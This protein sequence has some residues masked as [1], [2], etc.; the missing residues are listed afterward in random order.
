[1]FSSVSHLEKMLFT[2]EFSVLLKSGV[3]LREALVSLEGKARRGS[4]R[5]VLQD[6]ESHIENGQPLSQALSRFPKVFDPLYVNLVRIGEASGTLPENLEFLSHELDQAYRLRKKIQGILLYPSIVFTLA[7]GLGAAI[8]VF[9]LPRLIRLFNSFDVALP[10]STRIL[11]GVASFMEA[12]GVLF[13][14]VLFLFLV[15]WRVVVSLRAVRPYWHRFLLS[16]PGLGTFFQDVA[17]ARFCRDMGVML[18]SGLPLLEALETE[19]QVMENRALAR[20]IKE[21]SR[22]V[23]SGQSLAEELEQER[24]ALI[25][26]LATKMIA[27]GEKT[28]RLG[29]T[30]LYLE[31]FFETEVDRRVKNMTVLFE[32]MLLVA[33]GLIVAFLALAIL[34]PIYSLTGSVHR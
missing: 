29:E 7:L 5:K 28:G 22:A 32:P 34:T 9:I 31:N 33:I 25:P 6:I 12:N 23:A 3:P 15:A 27:D 1:M 24:Y 21:L 17:A 30:F 26:S 18:R 20:L 8:S 4:M 16:L 11:L 14:A 13:F 2:R 19:E 10:L